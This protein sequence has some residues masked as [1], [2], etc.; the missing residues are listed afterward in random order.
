[1]EYRC[2]STVVTIESY[3]PAWKH[4]IAI[5]IWFW[6]T[7]K[8]CGQRLRKPEREK[9]RRNP[10]IRSY[11]YSVWKVVVVVNDILLFVGPIHKQDVFERWLSN[12]GLEESDVRP[13]N[14]TS[15]PEDWAWMSLN[16]QYFASN[17]KTIF[18]DT[19]QSIAAVKHIDLLSKRHSETI[20]SILQLL[21]RLS[22]IR[23]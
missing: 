4:L 22:S 21:H 16:L 15:D 11:F 13:F 3:W 10:S 9:Q 7:W 17:L 23:G 20:Q 2:W 8:K 1:M 6:R 5:A 18:I 19:S 14:E 12:F